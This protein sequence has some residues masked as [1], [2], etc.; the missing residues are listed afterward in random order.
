MRIAAKKCLSHVMC[1]PGTSLTSLERFTYL[2]DFIIGSFP[3]MR[4]YLEYLLLVCIDSSSAYSENIYKPRKA[5]VL[6]RSL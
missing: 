5:D 2:Q 3:S 1:C 6:E 4:D